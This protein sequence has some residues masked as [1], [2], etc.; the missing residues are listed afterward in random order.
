M[1]QA[2]MAKARGSKKKQERGREREQANMYPRSICPHLPSRCMAMKN[3][4]MQSSIHQELRTRALRVSRVSRMVRESARSSPRSS[5]DSGRAIALRVMQCPRLHPWLRISTIAI[6]HCRSYQRH[7]NSSRDKLRPCRRRHTR[8]RL[9]NDLPCRHKRHSPGL[10]PHQGR[11]RRN[12]IWPNPKLRR[13]RSLR[14]WTGAAR[15]ESHSLRL[16]TPSS[17]SRAKLIRQSPKRRS[18]TRMSRR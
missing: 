4:D 7:R 6:Q 13:R 16:W 10:Q 2:P 8:I 17:P 3:M 1:G 11:C 5:A 18:R 9:G 14:T 15:W 12:R